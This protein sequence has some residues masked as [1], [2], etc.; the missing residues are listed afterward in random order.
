[1][2]AR[3]RDFP[4][5]RA[6]ADYQRDAILPAVHV[7]EPSPSPVDINTVAAP[8]PHDVGQI[9]RRRTRAAHRSPATIVGDETGAGASAAAGGV[10]SC[11]TIS[12][13]ASQVRH[14]DDLLAWRGSLGDGTGL[15]TD[16]MCSSGAMLAIARRE[17]AASCRRATITHHRRGDGGPKAHLIAVGTSTRHALAPKTSMARPKR[18]CISPPPG[19]GKSG[20]ARRHPQMDF[21]GAQTIL[22]PPPILWLWRGSGPS[23][24]SA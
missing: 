18:S 19:Q 23:H 15:K 17:K 7:G 6:P 21:R 24:R 11:R 20:G 22:P 12:A 13:P 1:M 14:G 2:P 4:C 9:M 5:A 10:A 3:G 8:I 16:P